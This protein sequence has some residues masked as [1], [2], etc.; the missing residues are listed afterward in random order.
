[1][2]PRLLAACFAL[3]SLLPS[4]WAD[5]GATTIKRAILRAGPDKGS[6]SLVTLQ[7]GTALT[8]V[9]SEPPFL[10]V[11]LPSGKVG[12]VAEHLV[13][14]DDTTEAAA[15]PAT[16]DP[17]PAAAAPATVTPPAEAASS[18]TP[19]ASS[20]EAESTPALPDNLPL[21]S[22]ALLLVAATAAG[23]GGGYRYRENYYRKKLHG[24][25]V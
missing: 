5:S 20:S 2:Y 15:A 4:A 3:F 11:Q 7:P 12:W 13:K 14:R 17:T 8:I 9:S 23:F 16:A 6:H 21:W 22:V 1:M 24:L 19:A 18:T 10:Q 25:R